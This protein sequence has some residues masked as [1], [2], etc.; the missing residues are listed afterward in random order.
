MK[1]IK[2]VA[3]KTY[4]K[5][6]RI[7]WSGWMKSTNSATVNA[8]FILLDEIKAKKWQ[9]DSNIGNP[10]FYCN[11]QISVLQPEESFKKE[12]REF[13]KES[14]EILNKEADFYEKHGKWSTDK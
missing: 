8:I 6:K 2:S 14:M 11:N 10:A 1:W 12:Q 13:E 3:Y 5:D 7:Y 4:K 9:K